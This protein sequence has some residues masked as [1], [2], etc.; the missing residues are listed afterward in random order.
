[1]KFI[2]LFS[3]LGGFHTGFTKSGHKC[4]F[5]SEIDENLRE[6]YEKNYGIKPHGDI[7]KVDEKDIPNHDVICAGFPCQPFSLAG[8]KRAH[9]AL[10]VVN[11]LMM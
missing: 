10:Q 11:L 7:T 6:L 8:Q 9:L 5:A 1:M 4:V 3:G 2:D